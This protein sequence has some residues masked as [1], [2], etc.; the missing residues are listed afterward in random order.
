V[1]KLVQTKWAFYLELVKVFYICAHADLEGNPFST[2]NGVDMV[3]D[4]VLWKEVAGLDMGG[5]RKFDETADS[6]NKMQN[7]RGML[8]DPTRRM[9]NRLGFGRPNC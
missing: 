6:C 3:I 7:Y 1:T 5:V 4:V 9:R 2:V 8:L